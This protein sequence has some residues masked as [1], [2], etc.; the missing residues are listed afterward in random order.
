[1]LRCPVP[2][3]SRLA[4]WL[5]RPT[6]FPVRPAIHRRRAFAGQGVPG[7]TG[8]RCDSLRKTFASLPRRGR[9]TRTRTRLFGARPGIFAPHPASNSYALHRLEPS[10]K[11]QEQRSERRGLGD[12]S[13]S[14]SW[15]FVL[16]LFL[17]RGAASLSPIG[18]EGW[19]GPGL[20]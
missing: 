16:K 7:R 15:R 10:D 17:R 2:S 3:S 13:R 9:P 5:G 8:G 6:S 20:G 19:G 1:M 11:R 14:I 4:S 12:G 18:G